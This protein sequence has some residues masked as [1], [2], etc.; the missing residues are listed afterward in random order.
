MS[1]ALS[2][3]E[4]LLMA[5]SCAFEAEVTA[6]F[7]DKT[8]TFTLA[9]EGKPDGS[10]T[11]A[12]QKPDAISG[13]KGALSAEGGK[14]TFD[15]DRA[16]AFPMLAEGEATP[17]S[18]VWILYSTLRSGYLTSCGTEGE[19]LRLTLNDTYEDKA[20]QVDVWLDDANCPVMA[21]ILWQSRRI[22]SLRVTNFQI[23]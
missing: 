13:I 15:E 3:R 14:I 20:M 21:E 16:L 11:F 4:Q 7:G 6:D 17:L 8:Y 10:L 5:K 18:A 23:L 19:W 1:R 9:C 22:L 12:V 2:F